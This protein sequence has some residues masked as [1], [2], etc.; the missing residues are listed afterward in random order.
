MTEPSGGNIF[1]VKSSDNVYE[2]VVSKGATFVYKISLWI[3]RSGQV[4]LIKFVS[5]PVESNS[6]HCML[7]YFCIT[8]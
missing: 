6:L 8:P 2:A 4:L 5:V 3:S 7:H 1:L